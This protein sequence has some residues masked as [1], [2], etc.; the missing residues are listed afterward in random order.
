MN[1]QEILRDLIRW[2]LHIAEMFERVLPYSLSKES[3]EAT[4]KQH[5]FHAW[6]LSLAL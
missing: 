1:D 4:I 6:V 3:V 5:R 2:H